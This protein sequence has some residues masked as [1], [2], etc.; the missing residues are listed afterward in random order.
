MQ[1]TDPPALGLADVTCCSN[2]IVPK[3]SAQRLCC[4][5]N[6]AK[7]NQPAFTLQNEMPCFANLVLRKDKTK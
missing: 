3:I 1:T 5:A 7:V 2:S 4:A 6:K